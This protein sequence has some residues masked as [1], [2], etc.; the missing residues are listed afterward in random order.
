MRGDAGRQRVAGGVARH[1]T[2]SPGGARTT[3]PGPH[4]PA[5]GGGA[6]TPIDRD[7]IDRDQ[8]HSEIAS[9]PA[10]RIAQVRA[11]VNDI[12]EIGATV[13]IL[14]RKIPK[15]E[16]ITIRTFYGRLDGSKID[17]AVGIPLTDHAEPVDG[18]DIVGIAGG[19]TCRDRHLPRPARGHRRRLTS[20]WRNRA[21]NHTAFIDRS[22]ATA[23]SSGNARS[24]KPNG[25]PG[26]LRS[27]GRSVARHEESPDPAHA[28]AA[29][30]PPPTAARRCRAGPTGWTR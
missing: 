13:D 21:W 27:P 19:G 3:H 14:L 30:P 8:R 28:R 18:L 29:G 1:A 20:L 10:Q 2:T 22:I 5:R 24:V 15:D 12:S 25:P 6:A 9:L 23:S 11:E 17:V 16:P 7:G 26:R 4:R